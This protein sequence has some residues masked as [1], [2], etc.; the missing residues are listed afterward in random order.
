MNSSF[1]SL[2]AETFKIQV[3]NWRSCLVLTLLE[4]VW[5]NASQGCGEGGGGVG[6]AGWRGSLNL[7]SKK[8]FIS[9]YSNTAELNKKRKLP[10]SYINDL[11][12]KIGLDC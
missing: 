7:K 3:Q 6:G 9:P 10:K 4:A 2:T 8:Q 1:G 5:L 12:L 11:K